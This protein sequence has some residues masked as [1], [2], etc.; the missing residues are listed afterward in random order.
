M[1]GLAPSHFPHY[2]GPWA[3]DQAL[4]GW[5]KPTSQPSQPTA[6]VPTHCITTP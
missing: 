1:F 3:W 6:N 5:A 2:E 4:A